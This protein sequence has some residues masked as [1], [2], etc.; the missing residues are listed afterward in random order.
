[1]DYICTNAIIGLTV[2]ETYIEQFRN[3]K[4]TSACIK[5]DNGDVRY[6]PRQLHF[7]VAPDDEAQLNHIARVAERQ[8]SAT[9]VIP[10]AHLPM[11]EVTTAERRK[12]IE[13]KREELRLAKEFDL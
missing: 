11:P 3:P 4:P 12:A 1:M 8:E 5:N 7:I 9:D 6:L 10:R 2:G 13:E